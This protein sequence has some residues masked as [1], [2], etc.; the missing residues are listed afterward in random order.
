MM[1]IGYIATANNHP[2]KKT[3]KSRA[4]KKKCDTPLNAIT[5]FPKSQQHSRSTTLQHVS[6][7]SDRFVS[8][9]W[10]SSPNSFSRKCVY[11]THHNRIK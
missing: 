2:K 4:E 3:N 6:I 10:M 8:S 5:I 1:R 9:D 7:F 11:D